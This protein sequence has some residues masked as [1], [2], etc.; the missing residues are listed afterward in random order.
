MKPSAGYLI[1]V[2]G[3]LNVNSLRNKYEAV[4][5]LVQNKADICLLSENK[6]DEIFPNQQFMIN[7]YKLFRRGRNC[8]IP[9]VNVEGT[10]K[11]C[12]IVLIE[13]SIK[14]R[15]WLFID[16]YKPPSQNENNFS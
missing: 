10:V 14:T 16:L 8:H 11:E 1:I 6:I 2:I 15:K 12:D 3:H 9:S 4:E 5:E 7:G 13:F